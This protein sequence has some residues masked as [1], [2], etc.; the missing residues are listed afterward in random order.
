[1]AAELVEPLI[2]NSAK[3]IAAPLT[4]NLGRRVRLPYICRTLR[5]PSLK[6]LRSI[7]FDTPFTRNLTG[8]RL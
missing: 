7:S 1:M 4:S 2:E 5:F 3:V 6:S 8:Q